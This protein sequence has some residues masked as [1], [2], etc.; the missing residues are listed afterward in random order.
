MSNSM[1]SYFYYSLLTYFLMSACISARK[2]DNSLV[3]PSVNEQVSYMTH[4]LRQLNN[5]FTNINPY[6]S[7]P[8]YQNQ[9]AEAMFDIFFEQY[10][11][12]SWEDMTFRKLLKVFDIYINDIIKIY[13]DSPNHSITAPFDLGL[14]QLSF[15]RLDNT[16]TTH[17]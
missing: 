1:E 7:G 3:F 15:D 10:G 11:K 2:G 9:I 17:S 12:N 8:D 16:V 14:L 4:S 6:R 13:F 5:V